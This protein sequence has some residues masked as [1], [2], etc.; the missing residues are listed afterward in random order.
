MYEDQEFINHLFFTHP[1]ANNLGVEK[2]LLEIPFSINH[3]D[4]ADMNRRMTAVFEF[5][6]TLYNI[7]DK[8]KARYHQALENEEYEKLDSIKKQLEQ[9]IN[10][11][12]DYEQREV[13]GRGGRYKRR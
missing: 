8:F 6:P 12:K 13:Y 1:W 3:P 5:D 4:K 10:D 2:I 7:A 11:I 9:V